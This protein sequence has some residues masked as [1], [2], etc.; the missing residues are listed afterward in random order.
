MFEIAKDIAEFITGSKSPY[1][2]M[3][4]V[5]ELFDILFA[6]TGAAVAKAF[7]DDK[8]AEKYIEELEDRL[9]E[10]KKEDFK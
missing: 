2:E 9:I 5:N 4:I 3:R 8:N 7:K 6:F 1:E 10:R